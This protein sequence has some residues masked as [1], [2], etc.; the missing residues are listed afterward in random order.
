MH[1]QSDRLFLS[2]FHGLTA[3]VY[4]QVLQMRKTEERV[5]VY[6]F[7]VVGCEE[8]VERSLMFHSSCV[9]INKITTSCCP[10][11]AAVY[12]G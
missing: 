6:R 9:L 3:D 7:Q 5:F 11:L 8:A 10:T 2:S 1:E 4:L 12:T